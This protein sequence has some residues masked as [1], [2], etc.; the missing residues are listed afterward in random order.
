[1]GADGD[2]PMYYTV[3]GQ[4]TYTLIH[5]VTVRNDR[6]SAA[7]NVVLSIPLTDDS[8]PVYFHPLR[9]QLTPYPD[10][11]VSDEQERR[12]A[13]YNI[14]RLEPG[15]ER[16]FYQK[17]AL[18]TDALRYHIDYT[19]TVYDYDQ[20]ALL[21]NYLQP[22]A[23]SQSDD[24]EI[25][26][27]VQNV[28]GQE[29]NPY[30]IA[31]MLYAAVNLY[32]DYQESDLPQDA[33]SVLNR[34]SAYCEGY[35]NLLVAL[36]RAAGIPARAQNGYLFQPESQIV[37]LYTESAN[38]WLQI[39]ALRHTWLEFYLPQA[40]WLF[41]DPSQIYT[42]VIDGAVN[43][44]VNWD[45]FCQ[46]PENSRY[47]FFRQG[48]GAEDKIECSSLGSEVTVSITPYLLFGNQTSVFNDV[49]GHW[50]EK[51]IEY[52]AEKGYFAGV[53]ANLFAPEQGVTRGMFV[54]V[55]GRMYEAGG[56][57]IE[58][59]GRTALFTDVRPEDYFAKYVSWGV[60]KG[61]LEGYGNGKFG[62]H[63]A[64][65]RQQ[66]AKILFAY[67]DDYYRS[68]GQVLLYSE[69]A[70]GILERYGDAET[71]DD[72]AQPGVAFC[73]ESGLLTGMPDGTVAPRGT[74]TRAQTAVI[75]Q[76]MDEY[77]AANAG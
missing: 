73:T 58:E 25:S 63:D 9:G 52:A 48:N 47:I 17:Y 62:P 44:F 59:T 11:I 64:I 37:D 4:W 12:F 6:N 22:D 13:I 19:A 50:A 51:A 46:I 2:A 40:G 16:T 34:R 1:G 56:G 20:I 42:S 74:A 67:L 30:L 38:D 75:L 33:K 24:W 39:N 18:S 27:Y 77:L 5:Q 57:V 70:A 55:L 68:R 72:W 10:A 21:S 28:I 66:M 3:N 45:F 41:C 31:K 43:K 54:T 8:V 15:E 65:N 76:R 26:Q 60:A 29:T 36:L 7:R 71:I 53:G 23:Y 69:D 35:V 32:V 49:A 61:I 14:S